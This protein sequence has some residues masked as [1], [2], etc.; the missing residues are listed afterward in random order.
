MCLSIAV[1]AMLNLRA[2]NVDETSRLCLNCN[3]IRPIRH[4]ESKP[5]TQ[6]A[7][8]PD[9]NNRDL[10]R[11]RYAAIAAAAV[12]CAIIKRLDSA[13]VSKTVASHTKGLS[14]LQ[15]NNNITSLS[16]VAYQTF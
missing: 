12:L 13:R 3:Y 2:K 16:T 6:T 9:C 4:T 1:V 8:K 10:R 14:I 7:Q 5:V 15:G 11:L